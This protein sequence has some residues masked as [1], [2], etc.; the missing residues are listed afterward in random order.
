MREIV[1]KKIGDL[2]LND[3]MELFEMG[4]FDNHSYYTLE[5]IVQVI[6]DSNICL[7]R[8]IVVEV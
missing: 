5:E 4:K 1:K 2:T 7:E 3:I 8:E 6:Q